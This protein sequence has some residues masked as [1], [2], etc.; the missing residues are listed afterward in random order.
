M[1]LRL[2]HQQL[3]VISAAALIAALSMALLSAINLRNGFNGYL[4]A[5][6]AL[7]LD[8]FVAVAKARLARDG[9]ETALH[10]G[11]VTL[12]SLLR[13]LAV[14]EGRGPRDG[15]PPPP[16]GPPPGAAPFDLVGGPP[17]GP[18]RPGLFGNRPPPPE[19]F[20]ARLILLDALGRVLAGPPGSQEFPASEGVSRAIRL[21]GRLVATVRMIPRGP[22]PIGVDARF[23]TTQ[24]EGAALL[25][26]LLLVLGALPAWG[27]ARVATRRISLIHAATDAIARG[28]LAARVPAHGSDELGDMARNINHMAESL[29]RLDAARRRWL[30][31]VSHELRSPLTAI[32]GGLDALEDGVRP[33]SQGA[34]ASLN[35][36][37][38]RLS[39]LVD[40]LHVLAMADLAALPCQFQ[41]FGVI[42]FC[43]G[44]FEQVGPQATAGQI[45]FSLE[46]GTMP[47]ILVQ[48]DASRIEQVL[49]NLFSNSLRYTD[50]PGLVTLTLAATGDHV[51]LRVDD[52]EPGIPAEHIG[53]IFEPLY[54]LDA[55]RSRATG[56]SGLGLAVCDA[57]VRAHRGTITAQPSPLGGLRVTLTLP[58]DARP[59]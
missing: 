11:R 57:I 24:Y 25:V 46:V 49:V 53:R 20:G 21:G 23:L 48:W 28:D 50:A 22:V 54:R 36:D 4:A 41:R 7:E 2:F 31:E 17:Q 12:H 59:S 19:D 18:P 26:L 40:D 8:Q 37:A 1:K 44:L 39:R 16:P 27:I 45:A 56:G 13:E 47:E 15:P 10:E 5:R 33:L 43:R 30:A 38:H 32:R 34:I 9:G 3:I 6:D 52:S 42:E 51:V 55:A 29:Q 58:F 35:E 14:A